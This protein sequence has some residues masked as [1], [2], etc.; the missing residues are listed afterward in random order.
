MDFVFTM[1]EENTQKKMTKYKTRKQG[2]T[3]KSK[4]E[5]K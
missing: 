2:K 4:F 1:R 5:K 3:V